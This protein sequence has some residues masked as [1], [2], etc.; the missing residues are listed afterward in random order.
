MG[1]DILSAEEIDEIMGIVNDEP[2]DVI[3]DKL[4]D[5]T[6]DHFLKMIFI[7]R[8]ERNRSFGYRNKLKDMLDT[9]RDY[10]KCKYV[11]YTNKPLRNGI[12]GD[13]IE[14]GHVNMAGLPALHVRATGG[15][16]YTEVIPSYHNN[17]DCF[18]PKEGLKE[19]NSFLLDPTLFNLI[20]DDDKLF[21]TRSEYK[22]CLDNVLHAIDTVGAIDPKE[23]LL[24]ERV[25]KIIISMA[26]VAPNLLKYVSV[27]RNNNGD[28]ITP[29]ISLRFTS[30]FIVA[31][32]ID[33]DYLNGYCKI[34]SIY[35]YSKLDYKVE[36]FT[37]LLAIFR[38]IDKLMEF[39]N[40]V[41][42]LRLKM[43]RDTNVNELIRKYGGR[44]NITKR[45]HMEY[46][47]NYVGTMGKY[48]IYDSY[49]KHI[50]H[51]EDDN[52]P[53][54]EVMKRLGDFIIVTIYKNYT[55]MITR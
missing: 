38:V 30:D 14:I 41:S 4:V 16:N 7:P 32:N 49:F 5:N 26:Y 48:L 12:F 25:K 47:S 19:F 34:G 54:N 43:E 1:S 21:E 29:S 44:L 33:V 35:D 24:L 17:R 53:F 39:V 46:L 45:E 42:I 52:V 55:R 15:I 37:D 13:E 40:E 10:Y 11:E 9:G 28:G 23:D 22:E 31:I 36:Y 51:L 18:V 50:H 2:I 27:V 3:F 6:Y 20:V 8:E